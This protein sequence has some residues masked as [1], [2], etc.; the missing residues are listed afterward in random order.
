M[1][2]LAIA[3]LAGCY[4]AHP[5]PGEVMCDDFSPAGT[6]ARAAAPL[7]AMDRAAV[8]LVRTETGDDEE[9]P[10][11]DFVLDG[12]PGQST[13]CPAHV[14]VTPYPLFERLRLPAGT[15][16]TL[17]Q[18]PGMWPYRLELEDSR[19][20]DGCAGRL[21]VFEGVL[22]DADREIVT[23]SQGPDLCALDCHERTYTIVRIGETDH[24]G[25]A[26]DWIHDGDVHVAL[27]TGAEDS[28]ARCGCT[29]QWH[30]PSGLVVLA[31]GS[32]AAGL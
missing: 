17:V 23:V 16:G 4:G 2:T 7:E 28:C 1:C 11:F 5:E 13:P 6:S 12:C 26:G 10:F 25:A 32:F 20:C 14:R 15:R 21:V 22:S 31:S 18:G 27:E 19:A 29:R 8:T 9:G 24:L 30:A 3:S